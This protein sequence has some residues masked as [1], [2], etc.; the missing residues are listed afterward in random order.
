MLFGFILA[1]CG[2]SCVEVA[3]EGRR[4]PNE[5]GLND[6]RISYL[7]II[8]NRSRTVD[9]ILLHVWKYE[10]QFLC[11]QKNCVRRV[12]KEISECG[13]F[14][15]HRN[16]DAFGT[17]IRRDFCFYVRQILTGLSVFKK[18]Q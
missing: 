17:T 3:Q 7:F 5:E 4:F 10:T 6:V 16:F 9:L 18:P 8:T 2:D 13:R 1:A 11:S 15:R 12:S 14:A